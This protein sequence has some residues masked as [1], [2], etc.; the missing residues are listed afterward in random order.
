MPPFWGMATRIM[1]IGLGDSKAYFPINP[2][3][4]GK[5][6][7]FKFQKL[8]ASSF[9]GIIFLFFSLKIGFKNFRIGG[10]RG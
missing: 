2:Q 8:L 7:F 6:W 1:K 4:S 9:I 10:L 3:F 5:E